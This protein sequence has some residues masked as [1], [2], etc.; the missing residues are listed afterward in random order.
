MFFSSSLL[1]TIPEHPAGRDQPDDPNE[2]RDRVS[3]DPG[4]G[5]PLSGVLCRVAVGL[6]ERNDAQHRPRDTS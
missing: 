1:L 6:H 4:D 3:D 2:E 5:D